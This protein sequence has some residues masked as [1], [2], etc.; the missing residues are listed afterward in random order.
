[1]SE[2]VSFDNEYAYQKWKNSADYRRR[3]SHVACPVHRLIY[4]LTK[5]EHQYHNCGSCG[6][7]QYENPTC[8]NCEQDDVYETKKRGRLRGNV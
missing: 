8:H 7:Q 2:V 1:M 6:W 4:F 5:K 3:L